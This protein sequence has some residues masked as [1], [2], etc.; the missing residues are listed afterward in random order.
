VLEEM[1]R[2]L[3]QHGHGGFLVG[4]LRQVEGQGQAAWGGGARLRR[5]TEGEEFQQVVRGV[6][7][8]QAEAARRGGRVDEHR[9]R[10]ADRLRDSLGVEDLDLAIRRQQHCAADAGDER[11][12]AGQEESRDRDH[13]PR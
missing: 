1:R 5:A 12:H 4:R 13:D 9:R 8:R 10:V 6:E 3:R 7:I 2:D 11:R